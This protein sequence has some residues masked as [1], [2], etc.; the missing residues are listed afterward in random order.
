MILVNHEDDMEIMRQRLSITHDDQAQRQI[1]EEFTIRSKTDELKSIFLH[2][3]KFLPNL[4]IRDE[5]GSVLPLMSGRDTEM[6]YRNRIEK[7]SHSEKIDLEKELK[8]IR[9][10]KKHI[11]V[12]A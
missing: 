1:T 10:E 12:Y 5:K 2:Y 11:R 3:V 7:S 4:V 8:E 6:L 9:D